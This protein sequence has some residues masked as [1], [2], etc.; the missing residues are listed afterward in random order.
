VQRIDGIVQLG[1]PAGQRL[2]TNVITFDQA[3]ETPSWKSTASG[4]K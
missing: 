2:G 3:L 4:M 1:Q